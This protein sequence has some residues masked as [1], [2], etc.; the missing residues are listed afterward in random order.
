MQ[1]IFMKIS[2]SVGNSSFLG[3][4][5]SLKYFCR[6]I[7]VNKWIFFLNIKKRNLFWALR[8]IVWYFSWI[9][10]NLYS[11]PTV[12]FVYVY[13]FLEDDLLARAIHFHLHVEIQTL[14][15]YLRIVN[16]LTCK[17]RKTLF[18]Q[19]MEK[20]LQKYLDMYFYFKKVKFNISNDIW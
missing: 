14:C 10:M 4:K 13:L 6:S 19:V 1:R 20:N 8:S 17:W 12:V 11:Y 16:L 3:N 15:C 7:I 2:I 18:N 9:E 5:Y